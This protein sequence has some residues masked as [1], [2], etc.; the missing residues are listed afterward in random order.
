MLDQDTGIATV[1]DERFTGRVHIE[2]NKVDSPQSRLRNCRATF[3]AEARTV[4]RRNASGQTLI[5]IAGEGRL[6]SE[7]GLIS[8]ISVGDVL[9]LPAEGKHWFG[10]S[11]AQSVTIL[12]VDHAG[13]GHRSIWLEPVSDEEYRATPAS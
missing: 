11:P 4:W 6:Q 8:K 7:G 10:A 3:E 12:F 2:Q 13:E 9:S 5:V 1:A